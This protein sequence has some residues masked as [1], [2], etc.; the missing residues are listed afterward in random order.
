MPKVDA[1]RMIVRGRCD[2]HY[3]ANVYSRPMLAIGGIAADF[4]PS[5]GFRFNDP[6]LDAELGGNWPDLLLDQCTDTL[7]STLNIGAARDCT[8]QRTEIADKPPC[9]TA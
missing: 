3:A 7:V 1:S 2:G 5:V 4:D 8:R 9:G 6:E